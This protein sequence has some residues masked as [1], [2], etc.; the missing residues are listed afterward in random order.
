VLAYDPA[1]MDNAR[2]VLGG[3]VDFAPSMSACVSEATV[4][5]IATA[6]DEF[7]TLDP[8]SLRTA[9]ARRPVIFDWWH[10]L[11]PTDFESAADYIACGQ[12]STRAGRSANPL[13]AVASK[14]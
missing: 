10:L 4:V 2:R 6:W 1:A 3:I 7:K 13:R 11:Q 8:K 5:V 14:R 12:G 9:A